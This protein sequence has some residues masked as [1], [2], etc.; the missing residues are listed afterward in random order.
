MFQSINEP[1]VILGNCINFH[2]TNFKKVKGSNISL[3]SKTDQLNLHNYIYQPSA[4]WNKAAWT[5][6]GVLNLKLQYSM[7]WDWFLRAERAGVKFIALNDYL[8]LF[9]WHENHKTGVKGKDNP[10]DIELANIYGTYST[11]KVKNAFIKL[12]RI[13]NNSKFINDVIH[14][15]NLFNIMPLKRLLHILLCPSI[16]FTEYFG[17]SHM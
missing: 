9:R 13:R 4:F 5:K 3:L 16:K 8:S 17:I 1:T 11:E 2:Q 15:S 10:R 6:T 7:D 12:R 14:A